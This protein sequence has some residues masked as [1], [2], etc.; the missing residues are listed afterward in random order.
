MAHPADTRRVVLIISSDR[1]LR[2]AVDK[3]VTRARCRAVAVRDGAA[4][5]QAFDQHRPALILVDPL[6]HDEL[7]TRLRSLCVVVAIPVRTSGSGIRRLAKP[8]TEAIRWL[9]ELVV[10]RCAATDELRS[11]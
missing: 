5:E 10:E 8:N 2:D 7:S 6:Q 11:S 3:R 1:G 9:T 4:A